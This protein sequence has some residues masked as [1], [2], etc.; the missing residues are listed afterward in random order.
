MSAL[1]WLEGI[2][3]WAPK[4]FRRLALGVQRATRSLE[5]L[6]T[7]T[8]SFAHHFHHGSRVFWHAASALEH[9]TRDLLSSMT[10]FMSLVSHL[11]SLMNEAECLAEHFQQLRHVFRS[12]MNS[13]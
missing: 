7:A 13:I 1:K 6:R 2:F 11:L 10:G 12:L 3:E 4:R 9:G 5:S 8:M